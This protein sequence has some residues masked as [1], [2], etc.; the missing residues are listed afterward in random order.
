[1]MDVSDAILD[2]VTRAAVVELRFQRSRNPRPWRE[3]SPALQKEW[4]KE[5][6]AIAS[7]VIRELKVALEQAK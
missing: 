4:T 6:R 1:M 3:L 7:A 5:G 2:R